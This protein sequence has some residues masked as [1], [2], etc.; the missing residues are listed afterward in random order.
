[1]KPL[2][3]RVGMTAPLPPNKE[4]GRARQSVKADSAVTVP[5]PLFEDIHV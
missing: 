5:L 1:M 4:A 3:A 2:N